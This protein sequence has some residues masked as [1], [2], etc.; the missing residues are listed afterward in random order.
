[1]NPKSLSCEVSF[2]FTMAF[3]KLFGAVAFTAIT[4]CGQF[5]THNGVNFEV[6]GAPF[7]FAGTNIYDGEYQLHQTGEPKLNHFS[8]LQYYAVCRRCNFSG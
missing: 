2:K 6:D 5:A 1:M 3:L 8:R 4:V 7:S